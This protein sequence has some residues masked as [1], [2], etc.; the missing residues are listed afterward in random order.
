MRKLFTATTIAALLLLTACG[1]PPAPP[2]LVEESQVEAT[3]WQAAALDGK[4]VSVDG[5]I[6]V[7]DGREHGANAAMAYTLTSRSRGQGEDLV[8]FQAE[9]GKAAN[10][11]DFPVLS[12]ESMP[13]FPGAPPTLTVDLKNGRFQD[14]SGASHPV[15]D[16][17]RVTGRLASG[18]ERE[19]GGSLTGKRYRPMLMDVTLAAAPE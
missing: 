9:L 18:A 5:Y 1:R 2:V 13:G 16:K 12:S 19:D 10:Q 15:T 3:L 17:V 14:G 8:L 11:V 7:D 6:H 4:R